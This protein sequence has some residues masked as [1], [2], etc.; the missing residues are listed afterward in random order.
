MAAFREL[1]S[2]TYK[3]DSSG[4]IAMPLGTTRVSSRTCKYPEVTLN[5][6]TFCVF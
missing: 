5:E 2:E 4:E 1:V 6:Y 3:M